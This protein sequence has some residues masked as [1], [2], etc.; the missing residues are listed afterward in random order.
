[1]KKLITKKT[2]LE[3]KRKGE[4]ELQID[5]QTLLTPSAQDAIREHDIKLVN[6]SQQ[7]VAES[8]RC[9]AECAAPNEVSERAEIVEMVMKALEEKGLLKDILD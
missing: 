1:M 4:K 3:L 6:I 9:C 2:I 8:S 7:S 5:E